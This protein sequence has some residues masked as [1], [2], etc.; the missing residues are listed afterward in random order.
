MGLEGDVDLGAAR[1][2]VGQ[3]LRSGGQLPATA[4]EEGRDLSSM[5]GSPDGSA[6]RVLRA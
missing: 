5:G 3:E 2:R 6:Y 4:I 1:V